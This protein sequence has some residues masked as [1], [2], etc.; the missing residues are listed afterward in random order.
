MSGPDPP[1]GLGAWMDVRRA[2]V[3]GLRPSW[4]RAAV[5]LRTTLAGVS[6]CCGTAAP[7][8]RFGRGP[9]ATACAA[10]GAAGMAAPRGCGASLL[11]GAASNAWRR[12]YLATLRPRF[13]PATLDQ[14]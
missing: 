1:D 10:R 4:T 7:G 3:R 13:T 5:A 14:R 2:P 11:Q 9:R 12:S 8:M 6:R